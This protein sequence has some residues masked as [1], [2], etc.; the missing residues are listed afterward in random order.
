MSSKEKFVLVPL[1]PTD[2]E[3]IDVSQAFKKT[4]SRQISKVPISSLIPTLTELL[5]SRFDISDEFV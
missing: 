1:S 5:M 2:V 3:Y 4:C